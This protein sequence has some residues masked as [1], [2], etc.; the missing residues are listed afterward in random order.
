ML[1]CPS[2]SQNQFILG[3]DR[4]L[5]HQQRVTLATAEQ[6]SEAEYLVC[7]ARVKAIARVQFM[8]QG[9]VPGA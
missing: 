1:P 6:R 2:G 8:L 9:I 7:V 3:D 5:L 4:R